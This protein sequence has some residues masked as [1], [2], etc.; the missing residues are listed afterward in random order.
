M[1]AGRGRGN[2]NGRSKARAEPASSKGPSP[3][4]KRKA[5]EAP[6]SEPCL[7]RGSTRA[8]RKH[9]RD[10]DQKVD[11]VL[12]NGRLDHVPKSIWATRTNS[13]NETV[14][15]FTMNY[16]LKHK[17]EV[18]RLSSKFWTLLFESFDLSMKVEL[19]FPTDKTRPPAALI[20]ALYQVNHDNAVKASAKPF[21]LYLEQCDGLKENATFG[22]LGAVQFSP[23]ITQLNAARCLMAILKFW[24]RIHRARRIGMS[25]I[26]FPERFMFSLWSRRDVG[27]CC[28]LFSM[29][30][31]DDRVLVWLKKVPS[32]H[33][34]RKLFAFAR[35]LFWGLASGGFWTSLSQ[36]FKFTGTPPRAP[37][38]RAAKPP[39]TLSVNPGTPNPTQVRFINLL[40]NFKSFTFFFIIFLS[41]KI[42]CPSCQPA[43]IV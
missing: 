1:A 25:K 38:K 17:C 24:D 28:F 27:H 4:R 12:A 20:E 23:S 30:V 19:P 34:T 16:L 37:Q 39:K 21:Q 14:R 9:R 18:Q 5:Q 11:R 31:A 40:C 32:R 22:M 43:Y 15:E 36:S 7:S 41:L 26:I 10:L 35:C 13:R 3:T 33:R 29:V 6:K 8:S 42:W 2:G